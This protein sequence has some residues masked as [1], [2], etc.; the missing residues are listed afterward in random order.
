MTVFGIFFLGNKITCLSLKDKI[1]WSSDFDFLRLAE[2][3]EGYCCED[4]LA[5]IR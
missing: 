4:W 2:T 3:Y 1:H 5:K